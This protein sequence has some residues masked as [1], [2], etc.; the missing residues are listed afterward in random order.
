MYQY[1]VSFG[2]AVT[3]AFANYCNF[4]GRASRSEFWWFYLFNIIII[5]ALSFF[6]GLF[7]GALG[8]DSGMSNLFR[9]LEFGYGLGVFLPQL[10]LCVRRLHDIGK[11]GWYLLIGLIPLVGAIV[12]LVY[13]CKDS[14]MYDNQYGPVPNM[15]YRN[16]W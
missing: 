11:S 16:Q 2:E 12:L 15:K 5:F 6:Q 9:A 10:G 13:Y 7:A 1:Q 14:E 8:F 3:R 4:E